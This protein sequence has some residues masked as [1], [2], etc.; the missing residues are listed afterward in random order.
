M[1]KLYKNIIVIFATV[2][3]LTPILFTNLFERLSLKLAGGE[4]YFIASVNGLDA[5]TIRQIKPRGIFDKVYIKIVMD[6]ELIPFNEGY[7]N[8]F[9]TDDINE[10]IRLEFSKNGIGLVYGTGDPAAPSTIPMI[11]RLKFY[12]IHHIEIDAVDREY[13]E[14]NDSYAGGYVTTSSAPN[15]S[16]SNIMI[17]RGFDD[18]RK[19]SGKIYNASI[20]ICDIKIYRRILWS[21]YVVAVILYVASLVSG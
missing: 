9:Q 2:L 3:F 19:F 16:I 8:L 5:G 1:E 20:S 10:G 6:Y 18:T 15:F 13:I 17:G 12:E 11:K 14:V 7:P 21:L 4:K